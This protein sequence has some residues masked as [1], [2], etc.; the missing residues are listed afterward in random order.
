[1][2]NEEK[3]VFL[4]RVE[5][6]KEDTPDGFTLTFS[7]EDDSDEE[8]RALVAD[9]DYLVCYGRGFED[10]DVAKKAKIFQVLSAGYDRLDIDAFTKAGIPVCNN[11]GANAPT[12][13][14]HAVMLMLAV[15]KKLPTHHNGLHNGEWLGHRHALVMRELRDKQVGIVGFGHIGREVA[16]IV[17][18][19]LAKPAFYDPIDVPKAVQEEFNATQ[20]PLDEL[21]ATSDVITVH[22]PLLD[23][24]RG[25]MNAAAFAK[26]KPSAIYIT[27]ARGPI[28][29]EASLIEA[30]DKGE[31]AGAGVDV[32]EQ[33]PTP[34]DNKLFGRE[35]VVVTPHMAGTTLD[36]WYRRL[37]FAFGN[38]Q[39][40][41]K[42]EAP[43][44]Q[45]NV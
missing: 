43:L 25:M 10:F 30:L 44:A 3:I 20:M 11:G 4:Y 7:S 15:Y 17:N 21:L 18:G 42:G 45:I 23:S 39:R 28:T 5:K 24:T 27:T 2:S 29:D 6:A 35:N 41:S 32:F 26:M 16:R 12:V 1:M 38:I 34:N 13:A 8:R 22:T 40:V 9:A 14:E 36:T 33:E 31:I 19:F 37:S